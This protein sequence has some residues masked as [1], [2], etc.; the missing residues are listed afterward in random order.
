MCSACV[1][2][3]RDKAIDCLA[4]WGYHCELFD[5]GAAVSQQCAEA[6]QAITQSATELL[7]CGSWQLQ[8]AVCMA[9][10]VICPSER[11]LSSVHTHYALGYMQQYSTTS[12]TFRRHVPS[13]V[14]L[15]QLGQESH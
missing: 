2:Q 11:K 13:T 7:G 9:V 3:Q 8:G 10:N 15:L 12:A 4:I 1:R 14:E 5:F 6:F